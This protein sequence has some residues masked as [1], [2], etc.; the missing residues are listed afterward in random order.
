MDADTQKAIAALQADNAKLKADLAKLRTEFDN[1]TISGLPG[2]GAGMFIP[3][4]V[5]DDG[6]GGNPFN[7]EVEVDIGYTG[8]LDAKII[9]AR[10]P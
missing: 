8:E 4:E 6:G 7:E 9:P 10:D 2:A 5:L 3:S 1:L